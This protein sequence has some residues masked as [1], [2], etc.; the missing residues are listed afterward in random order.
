MQTCK[1]GECPDTLYC[2]VFCLIQREH[3]GKSERYKK[4]ECMATNFH[5]VGEQMWQKKKNIYIC[6]T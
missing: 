4:Q 1:L 6:E 3:Q 2:V 5:I